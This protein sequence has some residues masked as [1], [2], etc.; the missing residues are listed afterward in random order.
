MKMPVIKNSK[1]MGL[2]VPVLVLLA[3]LL[4]YEYGFLQLSSESSALAERKQAGLKTLRKSLELVAR[5]GE[6]EAKLAS[7]KE[8]RK[9]DEAKIINGPTPSIAAASL[10]SSV[11]GI[12]SA[13][14]GTIISERAEKPEDAGSFRIIGVTIDAM[15]P[16]TRVLGD[17][18]FAIE[19]QTP[20]LSM[21]E[22]DIRPRNYREP[23]ELMVKMKITAL[24]MGKK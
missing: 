9:A 19:T 21:R 5:K 1:L 12:I 24:M 20:Y 14:G 2:A 18:L 3:A 8:L 4:L 22:L 15:F 10:Q 6:Y 7:L 16:E 13:R 17:T 23:R 11:K